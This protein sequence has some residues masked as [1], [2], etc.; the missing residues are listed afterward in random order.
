LGAVYAQAESPINGS[1]G[2]EKWVI[3]LMSVQ[4]D[5]SG[6]GIGT[7]LIATLEQEA[8]HRGVIK[9]FVFANETDLKVQGFY[10]KNGYQFAGRIQ[11]YQYGKNNSAVFLL[12]YL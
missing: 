2:L 3:N 11:D 1:E 4:P 9:I 12:K 8:R 6:A 10:Q 7:A 5:R